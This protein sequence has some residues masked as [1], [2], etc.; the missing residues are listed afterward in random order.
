[1]KMPPSVLRM[2]GFYKG[3]SGAGGLGGKDP[4][5]TWKGLKGYKGGE[6]VY[7]G[8]GALKQEA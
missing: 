1:M 2:L 7:E 6:W 5:E 3:A 4:V 8:K